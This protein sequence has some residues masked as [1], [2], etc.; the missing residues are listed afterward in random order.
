MPTAAPAPLPTGPMTDDEVVE[1]VRCGDGALFEVLIRRYNQPLY[2]AV[3]AILRDEAAAEDA[4]Q[5]AWIQAYTNLHAFRGQARFSTWLVTIGVRE[6]LGRVRRER[7]LVAVAELDDDLFGDAEAAMTPEDHTADRE[8]AALL[9]DAVDRLPLGYRQVFV[10]RLV[11]GLDT[12][13]TAAALELGEDVVK[14]RLHRARAMV[15]STLER[16]A[17]VATR[18]LF[19][20]HATRCGRVTAAVMTVI[21]ESSASPPAPA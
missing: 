6:A 16:R 20:F 2:R 12:A 15:R 19:E 11:E 3:R 17:D 14:Q 10:L 21:A 18:A 1:R 8:L 13:E 4:M 7:R 5:Q 9:E